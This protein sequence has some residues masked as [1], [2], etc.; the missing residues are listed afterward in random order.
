[1]YPQ[2]F[3]LSTSVEAAWLEDVLPET[4]ATLDSVGKTAMDVRTGMLMDYVL[5]HE[6]FHLVDAG[7]ATHYPAN[8][9]GPSGWNY[10]VK[11]Y[12]VGGKNAGNFAQLGF[13]ATLI[14]TQNVMPTRAEDNVPLSLTRQR[15][16]KKGIEKETYSYGL[17]SVV[18]SPWSY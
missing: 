6:V 10:S 12:D 9:Y 7:M 11:Y 3:K 18:S 16:L 8:E 15:G 14:E 13:A 5:S 1:M 17:V 4:Q 2:K